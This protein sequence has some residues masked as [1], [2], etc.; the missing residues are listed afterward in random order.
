[1]EETLDLLR[2]NSALVVSGVQE[3]TDAEL[4][5]AAPV[6]LHWNAPLTAQYFVEGHPLAHAYQHLAS[7]RAAVGAHA[8][9]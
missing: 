9:P 8:D 4:D 2:R 1:M 5:R 7:I 6:S 3:L